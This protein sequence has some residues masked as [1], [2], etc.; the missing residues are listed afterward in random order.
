[1]SDR[2]AT[3]V[4]R[5][6]QIIPAFGARPG[7]FLIIQPTRSRPFLL[8]RT[9]APALMIF[10]TDDAVEPMPPSHP[11]RH[12]RRRVVRLHPPQSLRVTK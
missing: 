7:D 6:K 12:W 5:A 8:Q 2:P 9:L 4:Y 10:L 3:L 1:M 11:P